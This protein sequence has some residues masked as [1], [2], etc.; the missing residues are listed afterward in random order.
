MKMT[1]FAMALLM[2][3]AA[4][5]QT[6]TE[7]DVDADM[8]VAADVDVDATTSVDQNSNVHGTATHSSTV[9]ATS[10]TMASSMPATGD[11]I[12]EASNANPEEDARGIAVISDPAIVPAG[13]NGVSGT[14]VGGPLVD[15]A[16]GATVAGDDASYPPCTAQVTD[17]CVQSYERGVD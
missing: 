15:P 4:V 14:A 2:S 10:Q 6:T 12:A 13:W 3:G 11:A 1:A 5:A 8:N 17:N 16:T 7:A 9:D